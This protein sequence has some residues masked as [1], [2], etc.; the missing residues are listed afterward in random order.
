MR[1]ASID[2]LASRTL[3]AARAIDK[4]IGKLPST[5]SHILVLENLDNEYAR[6][7]KTFPTRG[8]E[9]YAPD[10]AIKAVAAITKHVKSMHRG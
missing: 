10:S 1:N 5:I 9:L 7:F 6:A 3:S 4:S 8:Q 2:D